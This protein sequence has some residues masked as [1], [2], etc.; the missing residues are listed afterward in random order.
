MKRFAPTWL[1][2]AICALIFLIP[3]PAMADTGTA[4]MQTSMFHLVILNLFIGLLEA[5][6]VSKVFKTPKADT[7]H[8]MIAANYI[9]A[10]FGLA[11][12]LAYRHSLLSVFPGRALL[13]NARLS[14]V[15]LILLSWML[16]VL[17]E[18]PCTYS[19]VG[20]DKPRRFN[21]SFR[22]SLLAQTT[23]YALLV[24]M[25]LMASPTN[26]VVGNHLQRDLHFVKP[27]YATIFYIDPKDGGIYRTNLSGASRRKVLDAKIKDWSARLS[28]V[29]TTPGTLD[30]KMTSGYSN[31]EQTQ[32]LIRGMHGQSAT[33]EAFLCSYIPRDKLRYFVMPGFW[34]SDGIQF[35]KNRNHSDSPD[36]N[37]TSLAFDTPWASAWC[38]DVTVLPDNQ[39]VFEISIDRDQQV[40]DDLVAILDPSTQ[41]VGIITEGQGAAVAMNY[42]GP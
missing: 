17:I 4:L 32:I 28:F 38:D 39:A 31:E 13:D 2:I 16:T 20:N 26:L 33:Q 11:V 25:Y 21:R 7:R 23:S 29:K 30:L 8:L 40:N 36:G 34:A 15:V 24:P 5:K 19:A 42:A 3:A 9:S 37:F 14:M 22:A 12:V 18:W 10:F 41:K 1:T 6:V 27:V 35:D